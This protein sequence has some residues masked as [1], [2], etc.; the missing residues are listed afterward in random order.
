MQ[1]IPEGEVPINAPV[2]RV[3]EAYQ[4]MLSVLFALRNLIANDATQLAKD[5]PTWDPAKDARITVFWNSLTVIDSTGVG[6]VFVKG[7]LRDDYFWKGG[8]KLSVSEGQSDAEAKQHIE[9]GL[10][11][12]LKLEPPNAIGLLDLW[13]E[14]RN[15]VHNN[16]VYFKRKETSDSSVAYKGQTY[17][18]RYGQKIDFVDWKMLLTLVFDL[19]E[20]LLQVV[21]D[22]KLSQFPDPIHDLS[23]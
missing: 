3:D 22:P 6:L 13:R 19:R 18:F 2:S 5:N 8:L 9:R 21:N 1:T 10:E 11:A 4:P 17:Q 15:V 7:A 14:V 16:G 23:Q 12:F 20:M